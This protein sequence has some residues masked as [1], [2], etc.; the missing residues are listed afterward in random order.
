MGKHTIGKEIRKEGRERERIHTVIQCDVCGSK[1]YERKQ[2]KIEE[3]LSRQCRNCIAN[4]TREKK[5]QQRLA[6]DQDR[7]LLES[8]RS[9]HRL[10]QR[11]DKKDSSRIKWLS[12][13]QDLEGDVG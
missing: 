4:N 7:A 9:I 10:I 2:R 11:A 5:A 12:Y 1:S 6:S 8:L 13:L 3:A